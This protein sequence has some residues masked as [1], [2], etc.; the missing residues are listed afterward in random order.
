MTVMGVTEGTTM[1]ELTEGNDDDGSHGRLRRRWWD[2]WKVITMMELM[3]GTTM[4]EE[5]EGNDDDGTHGR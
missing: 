1:M 3:E 5:T 2:S 4:M